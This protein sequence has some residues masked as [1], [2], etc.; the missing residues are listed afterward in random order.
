M[1]LRRLAARI[2][3]HD[4]LAV[5]IEL[6]VV[7]AGVFIALQVSNWNDSRKE[8][9]L[10]REYLGRLRGELT[11][12]VQDLRA[13]SRFWTRVGEYGKGAV[14][15]AESGEMVDGSAWKTLLAYY[16]ASQ[17][18][19]YRKPDVTFEEIRS[20]GDLRLIRNAELRA[21]IARHY[22]AGAG[23]QV[24]E[25]LA[26][27]PR[28]RERVRGMTPWKIQQY[29]WSSC[30]GAENTVQV[31]IDCQAPVSE[32]ASLAVLER[33]RQSHELTDDLRF[34]MVN[35]NNGLVLMRDIEAE[36]LALVRDL[37]REVAP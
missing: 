34:W 32:E 3:Q 16:Q 31:L 36:A 37:E 13:I 12:D 10:G 21:R 9:A 7:V 1:A 23:S 15:Y 25:V 8:S 27:I 35:L 6:L 18:W 2:R 11:Q 22:S 4:W 26:L 30:Y 28:Y 5:G 24:S 33:Y 17:V 29:I 14:A 20:S 19:P